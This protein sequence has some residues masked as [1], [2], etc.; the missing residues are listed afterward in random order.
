MPDQ[1]VPITGLHTVG[2]V[3]DTPAVAL[4]PNAFSDARNVRFKDG[5]VSKMEGDIN[6]FPYIFNNDDNTLSYADRQRVEYL[7][8]WPNPFLATSNSGYYVMVRREVMSDMDDTLVDRAYIFPPGITDITADHM[9][10]T[11][12]TGGNWQHTFFQGGF[13]F[14]LNNGL[15]A[16][17]YILDATGN[18]NPADVP[19]FEMLPGWE[20]YQTESVSGVFSATLD[21]PRFELSRAL[22][23]CYRRNCSN[24][25]S[26]R[27]YWYS[28]IL[29]CYC[30]TTPAR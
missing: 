13:A 9:K 26:W 20:S 21:Q 8:Y 11:F 16:P 6:M 22:G 18:D 29:W 28:R 15:D 12:T 19:N 10:G 7:A 5:A 25:Y 27:C 3:Q 17:H 4:P 14:I 2:V 23:L 24:Y 30:N 1:I